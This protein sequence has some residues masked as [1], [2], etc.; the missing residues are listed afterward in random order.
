MWLRQPA[1]YLRLPAV[2]ENYSD[3]AI[4]RKIQDYK[5]KKDASRQP[6]DQVNMERTVGMPVNEGVPE[7]ALPPVP[8]SEMKPQGGIAAGAEIN[9]SSREDIPYQ[10][11]QE[12]HDAVVPRVRSEAIRNMSEEDFR[13]KAEAGNISEKEYW[14][15]QLK[16]DPHN[17]YAILADHF[18][19]AE[20]PEE[21]KKRE[22]REKI[23]DAISGL[24]NVISNAVNL[25]YT[26]KGAMP[27]D[28]VT[29][30][31]EEDERRRRIREKRDALKERQDALLLKA[32]MEDV[33]YRRG[34][35][36][37][38]SKADAERREKVEQ[39]AAD[40]MKFNAS[41]S[42]KQAKDKADK[43]L[44]EK[45]LEE[46]SRHNRN[47]EAI[48]RSRAATAARQ[49]EAKSSNDKNYDYLPYEDSLIPVP[50]PKAKGLYSQLYQA[51]KRDPALKGDRLENI[52]LQMGEGGDM[53][54]KMMN[55]VRR[56]INDSPAAMELLR[57]YMG[58]DS[59]EKTAQI[60]FSAPW[61]DTN[62]KR[63][64]YIKNSKRAPYL[65]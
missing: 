33:N 21:K 3:M 35:A 12:M 34:L 1:D 20:T 62:D 38:K 40:L 10:N 43:E 27:I 57:Q 44:K 45:Q 25:Y 29:P 26:S 53:D 9:S 54:S 58:F 61:A 41:L 46:M 63:A 39:R 15:E 65:N 42:Y 50:K 7:D 6:V 31:K 30:M 8:V 36:G 64:P 16:K 32:K 22:R 13:N 23:E 59:Q 14:T 28:F 17:A 52:N 19:D 4:L 48:G 24:G 56:R 51:M 37:A 18:A 47:T 11:V 55:T 49:A 5:E 2:L 60:P